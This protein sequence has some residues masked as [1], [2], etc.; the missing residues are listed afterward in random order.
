[1]T[2]TIENGHRPKN[3]NGQTIRH[4]TLRR[5]PRCRVPQKT[6]TVHG[7]R[8]SGACVNICKCRIQRPR[9]SWNTPVGFTVPIFRMRNKKVKQRS[10][11]E[12]SQFQT[13]DRENWQ[14]EPRLK[15]F[16]QSTTKWRTNPHHG[17]ILGLNCMY[18][19]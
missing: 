3:G 18:I 7:F 17:S 16:R 6:Q 1:M 10:I 15:L 13:E 11:T 19:G 12:V 14:K 9:D 2:T 8:V 4:S 5:L